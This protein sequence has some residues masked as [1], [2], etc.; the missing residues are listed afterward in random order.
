M[1]NDTDCLEELEGEVY[2]NYTAS[3]CLFLCCVMAQ[4]NGRRC[5]SDD[6]GEEEII[7]AILFVAVRHHHLTSMKQLLVLALR[8]M[9]VITITNY[10]FDHMWSHVARLG[11][12]ALVWGEKG[13]VQPE[14]SDV[15]DR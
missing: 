1:R 10:F 3:A 4:C 12:P 9:I 2:C 14:V 8:F 11:T 6:A 15:I 7:I 5:K 13:A